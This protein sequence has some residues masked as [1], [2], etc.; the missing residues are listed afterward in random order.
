MRRVQALL[1]SAAI[2]LGVAAEAAFYGFRD[3]AEWIPDLVTGW[4]LIGCGLVAWRGRP[5]SRVGVLL[6][7]SGFCW[8]LGN[9]ARSD[10]GVIAWSRGT[11]STCIGVRS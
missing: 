6:T 11:G 5:G 9:F 8:F 3:P 10:V 7:A 4:A 2:A 1:L